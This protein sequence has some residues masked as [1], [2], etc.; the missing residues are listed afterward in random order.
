L[1]AIGDDSG[2]IY[3]VYSLC[4]S[5]FSFIY[6]LALAFVLPA[7][8]GILAATDQLGD[9]LNP[10]KL[11]ALVRAAPSAYL[12]ALVGGI[13]ASIVADLGVILCVVGIFFTLA[14]AAAIT[15]H[16]YGQAYNQASELLV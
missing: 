9:A 16:L 7:S 12:M 10:S 2:T 14:Y 3:T 5:C 13:G 15:G 8:F 11:L 4:F 1:G 6:G